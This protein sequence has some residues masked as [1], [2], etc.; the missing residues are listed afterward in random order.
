MPAS[1]T[2]TRTF[3]GETGTAA[4]DGLAGFRIGQRYE[5][6]YAP[7]AENAAFVAIVLPQGSASAGPLL[8][9]VVQFEKWFVK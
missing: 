2:E 8:L 5:L 7:W 4:S 3:V 9:S 1:I 6:T